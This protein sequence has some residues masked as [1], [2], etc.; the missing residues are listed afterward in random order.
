MSIRSDFVR[1]WFPGTPVPKAR[2]RVTFTGP[3][4]RAYTSES[5]KDWERSA[6]LVLANELGSRTPWKGPVQLVITIIILR[7]QS[8]KKRQRPAVRPDGDNY[9]KAVL[10]ALNGHLFDDDGQVVDLHW[11][12]TYTEDP[13]A[14]GVLVEAL[15]LCSFWDNEGRKRHMGV[16]SG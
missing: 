12:K 2:A 8:A 14:Q 11:M 7:P 16:F 13:A 15:Q 3:R 9:E 6:Q 10:D 5:T 1:L 4:A